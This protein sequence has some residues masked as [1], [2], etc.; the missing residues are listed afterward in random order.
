VQ[1]VD[2]LV[3]SE[4]ERTLA[5]ALLEGGDQIVIDEF[6]GVVDRQVAKIGSD[7]VQKFIRK[8]GKKFVAVTCHYDV[9][10]WLRPEWMLE[11]ATMTFQ[12]R[13]VQ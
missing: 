10:E 11:P 8:R 13:S 6:T 7:A 3:E 1:S 9:I 5:R 12:W 2:L 4:L